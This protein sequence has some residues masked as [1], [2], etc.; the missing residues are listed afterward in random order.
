MLM[1]N[2]FRNPVAAR[3][4]TMGGRR[5]PADWAKG[6]NPDTVYDQRDLENMWKSPQWSAKINA[7]NVTNVTRDARLSAWTEI[8]GEK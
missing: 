6:Q 3:V 2:A 1:M 5:L 8:L 7:E 4:E